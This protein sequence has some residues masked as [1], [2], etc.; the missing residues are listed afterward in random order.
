MAELNTTGATS[1]QSWTK[2]VYGKVKN[3]VPEG[4][5][6]LQE[7]PFSEAKKIGRTFNEPVIMSDEVGLTFAGTGSDM[8]TL[9]GSIAAEIP[10][11]SAEGCEIML[12]SRISYKAF[13]SAYNSGKASYSRFYGQL[14][15]NM[16]R[17]MSKVVEMSVVNGNRDVGVVSAVADTGAGTATITLTA[18]SWIPGVFVG[19]KNI[20]IDVYDTTGATKRNATTDISVT[21]VDVTD[22]AAVVL[23]L[24][25]LET[26]LDTIVA[27]DIVYLKGAKDAICSGITEIA[28]LATG[29][30]YLGIASADYLDV[31]TGNTVAVGG[32]F[33]FAKLQEGL[34]EAHLKGGRGDHCVLVSPTAW[35]HLA[36]DYDAFRS[37]DSSYS[38]KK[39]K[40]GQ[41]EL[42]FHTLTGTAT[43]KASL[44]LRQSEAV[45][46]PKDSFD[47]VGSTDADFDDMA[48]GEKMFT[49]EDRA[50][51]ESRMYSDQYLHGTDVNSCVLWTGIA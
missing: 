13:H 47:R 28:Q 21:S 3:L 23:S 37:T 12:Q 22:H 31:W 49:L 14:L 33:S 40:L 19:R 4:T 39:G 46:F 1:M 29:D 27:T 24:S 18:G 7:A 48:K 15:A 45:A 50:A 8:D 35:R 32:N 16:R 10:E 44:F 30:T 42:E 6:M 11:A 5:H 26:E 25:G 34:V 38:E 51:W 17:S 2:E 9:N 36:D 43:I 20:K 41:R